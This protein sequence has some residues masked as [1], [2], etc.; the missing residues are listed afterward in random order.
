M[1]INLTNYSYF[2][3]KIPDDLFLSLKKESEQIL[4]GNPN[5]N[6]ERITGLTN[7]GVPKHFSLKV[8]NK[9]LFDYLNFLIPRVEK[10]INY[11]PSVKTNNSAVSL[12]YDNPWINFQR[13]GEYLPN[14]THDG[15]YSYSIWIK[16][17]ETDS[18][19]LF[20]GY[21]QFISPSVTGPILSTNLRIDNSK[22]GYIIMFPSILMHCVYPFFNSDECRISISGNVMMNTR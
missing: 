4:N 17:I 6:V 21:F 20:S 13:K 19:D 2:M 12:I 22:E 11:F 16:G 14:H 1:K 18:K 8:S 3:E 15:I 9:K 10:E 5:K 7:T